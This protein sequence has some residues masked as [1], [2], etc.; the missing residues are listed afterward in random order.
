MTDKEKLIALLTEFGVD[1]EQTRKVADD[2][3]S[4]GKSI[5]V[6]GHLGFY[7][8]YEFNNDGSFKEMGAY[9]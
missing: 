4:P 2:L 3:S 1:F 5:K 8:L 7:T 9:E 6:E